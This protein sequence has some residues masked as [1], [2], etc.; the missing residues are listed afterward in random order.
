MTHNYKTA[1]HWQH[2][3]YHGDPAQGGDTL[4][5]RREVVEERRGAVLLSERLHLL[6]HFRHRGQKRSQ[7]GLYHRGEDAQTDDEMRK[8][9]K[10]S[11]QCWCERDTTV[12]TLGFS[13]NLRG[14]SPPVSSKMS[15]SSFLQSKRNFWWKHSRIFLHIMDF[16]GV[17]TV[18][19][20]NESFSAASKGFKRHQTMN[21]GLI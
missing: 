10:S 4:T 3:T 18:Q 1:T 15:M 16:N 2:Q 6:D 21:K 5:D 14:S 19:G 12:Q 8:C 20:S 17:Q 7:G 13:K 11:K 9:C